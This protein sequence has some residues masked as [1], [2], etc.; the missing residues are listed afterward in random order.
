MG[1]ELVQCLCIEGKRQLDALVSKQLVR[2]VIRE[3]DGTV[4]GYL[5]SSEVLG[6][7]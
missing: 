4:Q 5:I 2:L 1:N 6:K 7:L 3:Q